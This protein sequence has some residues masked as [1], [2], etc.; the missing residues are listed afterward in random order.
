MTD[1]RRIAGGPPV[2]SLAMVSADQVTI[3]GNGTTEHPLRAAVGAD[4]FGADFAGFS[5]PKLGHAVVVSFGSSRNERI[6]VTP[7]RAGEDGSAE[8]LAAQ[9][10]GVIVAID[11]GVTVRTSGLVRLTPAEWTVVAGGA[12]DGLVAGAAYYLRSD[13]HISASPP[14]AAGTFV[15]QVGVA[16]DATTLVLSVPVVPVRN[17]HD[18]TFPARLV[19]GTP[20]LGQAVALVSS[21]L[22]TTVRPGD[23]TPNGFAQIA[24]LVVALGGVVTVQSVGMVTLQEKDWEGILDGRAGGL[25]PGIPYYLSI[26]QNQGRLTES[27]PRGSGV[28]VSQVGFSLDTTTMLLSLPSNTI[29]NP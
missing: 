21:T 17:K 9:V 4:T 14:T 3:F 22:P 23:A 6:T 13:G 20:K 5:T 26:E 27:P 10:V 8:L 19:F 25:F 2:P 11:Q 1:T 15:A 16:L 24:G 29:R 12:G 18:Q 7:G 28:F